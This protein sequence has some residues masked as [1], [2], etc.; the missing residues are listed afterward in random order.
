MRKIIIWQVIK[1]YLSY[2][3]VR[4]EEDS[5]KL[6]F[7][8]TTEFSKEYKEKLLPPKFVKEKEIY[9]RPEGIMDMVR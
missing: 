6:P 3:Q 9:E 4:R 8:G 5:E 2:W 7:Y 1:L